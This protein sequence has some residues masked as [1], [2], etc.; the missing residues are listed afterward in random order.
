[1]QRPS[2]DANISVWREYRIYARTQTSNP[3]N[4]REHLDKWTEE[5]Q[6]ANYKI[7]ILKL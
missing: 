4:S 2:D 7:A 1:M 5:W 3:K 6:I